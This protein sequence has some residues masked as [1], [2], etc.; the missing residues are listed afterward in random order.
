MWTASALSSESHRARAK[1]WRV[2]EHQHTHSTRKL[3][4]TQDEQLILEAILEQSKPAYPAGIEHLDYLLKT[5]FRYTPPNRYGSRFRTAGSRQ[6]V[7]Y[8][9][10]HLRS[11]LAETAFYRICFFRQSESM[12]LPRPRQQLT[13][14]TVEYKATAQLDL[15]KPPLNESRTEWTSMT[16]YKRTQEL[17]ATSR[18]ANIDVIRYESVR[19]PEKGA[20]IALLDFTAFSQESPLDRQTWFLYIAATEV[21]FTRTHATDAEDYWTFNRDH[22]DSMPG[23]IAP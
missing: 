1:V 21:N 14:F 11:A 3:V 10:E 15:T 23:I 12:M 9:A 7:F 20:N 18:Q 8:A 17:A 16:S 19:D 13:A 4:D 22:F 2:V 6:G 5:P